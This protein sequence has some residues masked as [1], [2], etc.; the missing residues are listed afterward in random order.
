MKGRP[1]SQAAWTRLMATRFAKH[2][3]KVALGSLY[4]VR[5][6]YDHIDW[7]EISNAAIELDFPLVLLR[8]LLCIY[9][10][11]RHIV[12]GRGIIYTASR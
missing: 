2:T 7:N 4:D 10:R 11:V 6:A 8:F 5:K 3:S 9:A 12:I 1:S